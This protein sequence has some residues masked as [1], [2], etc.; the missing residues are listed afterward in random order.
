AGFAFEYATDRLDVLT[1]AVDLLT[2]RL[3]RKLRERH[4]GARR[5]ECRLY[6]DMAEPS[7]IEVGLARP[8]RSTSHLQRLLHARLERTTLPGPV[9]GI[10]LCVAAAEPLDDAQAGLLDDERLP[11]ALALSALIDQLSSR[12]GREA[13][14]SPRLVADPQPE[15]A[16][17]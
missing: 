12:L 3:H 15:Y 2:D 7:V 5:L 14:T 4:A 13:V 1:H 17:R 16:C 6:H 10:H 9:S 11:D 8:S